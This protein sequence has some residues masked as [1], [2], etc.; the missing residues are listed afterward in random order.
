MRQFTQNSLML[1]GGFSPAS[2]AGLQLWLDASSSTSLVSDS[3]GIPLDG[4]RIQ[5]WRDRSGQAHDADQ[6]DDAAPKRPEYIRNVAGLNDRPVVRFDGTDDYLAM[7]DFIAFLQWSL[8]WV[9]RFNVKNRRLFSDRGVG[10]GPPML[11]VS[12]NGVEPPNTGHLVF[13]REASGDGSDTLTA[14]STGHANEYHI[15]AVILEAESVK[16][17]TNG[18]VT[19]SNT[20]EDWEGV[21]L[22][23]ATAPPRLGADIYVLQTFNGDVGEMLLYDRALSEG[24]REV[25][26]GY[27]SG[28]Y[29]IAS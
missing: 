7:P 13:L 20:S 4:D 29:G 24:E 15:G 8:F 28:K 9:A 16:I 21:D 12:S 11:D 19:G 14:N 3:G 26:Q 10:S 23:N 2:I 6:I 18:V 25:I 5:T 17:Y 27:L 22:S 1:E